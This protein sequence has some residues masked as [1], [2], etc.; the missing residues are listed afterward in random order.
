MSTYY[1]IINITK[2]EMI[3]NGK[4]GCGVNNK[5]YMMKE[6]IARLLI[7]LIQSNY[8]S[9]QREDRYNPLQHIC[10]NFK[11][12][13]AG[14]NIQMVSEHDEYYEL[15]SEYYTDITIAAANN[16]NEWYDD[17]DIRYKEIDKPGRTE[18][19]YY[20]IERILEAEKN[21]SDIPFKNTA[22]FRKP[23]I[24]KDKDKTLILMGKIIEDLE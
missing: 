7:H 19:Q 22:L 3:D 16:F 10:F 9:P 23:I 24:F 17:D 6:C 18:K 12:Y 8:A 21:I 15:A 20:P 5:Q 2:K 14:D 11:G 1:K 4:V 13:W